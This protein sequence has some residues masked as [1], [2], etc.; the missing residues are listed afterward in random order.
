[1]SP[2]AQEISQDSPLHSATRTRCSGSFSGTRT[3][4]P[5]SLVSRQD[6]ASC[7]ACVAANRITEL[8]A[9]LLWFPVKQVQP[10]SV[11]A[12]RM[13][14]ASFP[15][16]VVLTVSCFVPPCAHQMTSLL[17]ECTAGCAEGSTGT[18]A[19]RGSAP[20]ASSP[21]RRLEVHSREPSYPWRAVEC[22]VFGLKLSGMSDRGT[23]CQTRFRKFNRDFIL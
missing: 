18:L 9:L 20:A 14:I 19:P 11:R 23:N 15:G 8:S 22:H 16:L 3:L 2:P 5:V 6:G 12:P 7:N 1:M 17:A 21:S 13:F 10:D 4:L